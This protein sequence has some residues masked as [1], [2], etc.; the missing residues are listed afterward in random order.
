MYLYVY[1]CMNV[2]I[3][4]F[5][6]VVV[7]LLLLVL[8]LATGPAT[9]TAIAIATAHRVSQSFVRW[10]KQAYRM[11]CAGLGLPGKARIARR[12]TTRTNPGGMG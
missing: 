8:L 11:L 4:L 7:L 10:L 6:V 1:K 12:G 3:L 9:A 2:Y 5:V